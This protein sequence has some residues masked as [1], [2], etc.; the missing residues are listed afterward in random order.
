MAHGA[1]RGE[2]APSTEQPNPQTMNLD[3]LSVQEL[4]R[5]LHAEN[6]QPAEAVADALGAVA[7]AIEEIADR[8]AVGGRL[9][10]VG[11]GTSGRLGVLDASECPPTF[12]VPPEMVQGVIAGG[13]D[14]L[15]VSIEGAEDDPDLGREDILRFGLTPDDAVVGIAASGRTPYVMGALSAAREAG[16]YTVAVVNVAPAKLAEVADLAIVA[17]T[18]P[19]AITGSTRLKA[20]TAQKMIL[21]LISTGVM[22]CLGKTYGNLM[23][24]VR[25]SNAK[26]RDRAVRIVAAVTGCSQAEAT[27]ALEACGWQAKTAIVMLVHGVG[28][29]EARARIQQAKGFLRRALAAGAHPA[30]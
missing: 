20:G 21:N 2:E 18:G 28:A 8:L 15:R 25:A 19:E 24:D 16:A 17:R 5:V 3:T 11:A 30:P 13:D 23:V 26:L 12:G 22:V 27:S 1:E 6:Y 4:V 7:V 29:A 9:F 14:A 10:Y